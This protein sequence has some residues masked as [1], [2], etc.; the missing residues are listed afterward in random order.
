MDEW[1]RAQIEALE[2]RVAA[3]ERHVGAGS[4]SAPATGPA[5]A[6]EPAPPA[7]AAAPSALEAEIVALLRGGKA[8]EAIHTYVNRTGTDMATAKAEV[9]RI[10]SGMTP[11]DFL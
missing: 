7:D 8:L 9:A 3:L 2:R 4:A 6:P 11:Q 10:A 5:A 1:A